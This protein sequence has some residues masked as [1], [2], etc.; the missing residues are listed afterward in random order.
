MTWIMT[1]S[2]TKFDLIDTTP[3][4][5]KLIDIAHV[6]SKEGRF[7]FHTLMDFS[8]AQHC[9]L[10]AEKIRKDGYNF[11]FQL[12]FALHDATETW[13][14]DIPRPLKMLLPEYVVIEKRI[15][16]VVWAAFGITPPTKDEWAV[17]KYYDDLM[18]SNETPKL[19]RFPEKFGL[20]LRDDGINIRECDPTEIEAMYFST[21]MNLLNKALVSN[22]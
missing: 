4:M 6:L 14:R 21:V 18:L 11:R 3:D 20:E 12:L 15:E 22:A 10:G 13:L 2:G 16:Q 17:V 7:A 8:V 1:Y 19:M 9:L 5:V